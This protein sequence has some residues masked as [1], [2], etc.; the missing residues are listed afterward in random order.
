MPTLK[1]FECRVRGFD[2][3]STWWAATASKAR[4]QYWR[5]L[6]DPCPDLKFADISVKRAPGQ[7]IVFPD[8]PDV[9]ENLDD[10]DRDT[11]LHA[12]GGSSHKRVEHWGTRNHYCCDPKDTRLNRLVSLGLFRGPKGVDANGDTPGWV[13]AFFYLTDEGK[14]VARALIGARETGK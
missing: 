3:S 9:A 10:E 1:A 2:E 4:A 6:Q 8:L 13:G 5:F 14:T 12:F 7:D 11:I